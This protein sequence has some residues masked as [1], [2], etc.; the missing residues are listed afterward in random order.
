MAVRDG[1]DGIAPY[2]TKFR[3]IWSDG[4]IHQIRATGNV[5]CDKKCKAISM[6]G[7]NWDVT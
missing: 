3:I 4:S 7:A 1:I 2:D 6:I 5:I